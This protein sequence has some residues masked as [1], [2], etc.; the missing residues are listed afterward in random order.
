MLNGSRAIREEV[1]AG[2]TEYVAVTSFVVIGA[3]ACASALGL[4]LRDVIA[5]ADDALAGDV[6]SRT[7][8]SALSACA[9][10][11]CS[12]FIAGTP[13]DTAEGPRPIE[14]VALGDRVGPES[15]ECA[16][17]PL[18]GWLEMGAHMV[19][20]GPAGPDELDIRLLRPKASFAEHALSAGDRT[21][22]AVAELNVSG[23]GVVSYV[24][25]GPQLKPG[26]RCPAT[27]LFRHVSPDVITVSLRGG[28]PLEVTR[29][30]P[31]FSA[32]RHGWVDAGEVARGERLATRDGVAAVESVSD[33][34]RGPTEVFN[35]EV[36]GEHRYFV[37]AQRV[38][39]HN[40]CNDPND[41]KWNRASWRKTAVKSTWSSA[42]TGTATGTKQC[43]GCG[44]DVQAHAINSNGKRQ[45]A[46]DM[47]HDGAT[48]AQRKKYMLDREASTGD[49]YSRKEIIEAYHQEI[50]LKCPT[51]NRSHVYE[52]SSSHGENWSKAN[53]PDPK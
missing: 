10:G 46:W 22:I 28:L 35:L 25:A 40:G 43:G 16:A 6:T 23:D 14:Q 39:A 52:P 50:D 20:D 51:C 37:G 30:H 31:L 33:S 44:D 24:R 4:N 41:K 29:H 17:L 7:A 36:A 27:G 2:A 26:D 8:V 45:R 15:A 13:V 32:D 47:D 18:E 1:G 19:V 34:P 12:C 21:P 53:I 38:V 11:S 49:E 5:R 42:P 3:I 48:W 9:A